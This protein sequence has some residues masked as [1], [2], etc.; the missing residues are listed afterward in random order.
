SKV[1]CNYSA[2]FRKYSVKHVIASSEGA[3]QSL[4]IAS[5]ILRILS[6]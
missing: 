5:S 1:I 4:E 3:W 6:Q 2:L